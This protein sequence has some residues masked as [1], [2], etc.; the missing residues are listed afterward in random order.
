[1][2]VFIICEHGPA[3][4][5]VVA[6][7][8]VVNTFSVCVD[9][10]RQDGLDIHVHWLVF[11][12]VSSTSIST[13][14]TGRSQTIVST[15]GL[16]EHS[17]CLGHTSVGLS[18]GFVFYIES[19]PVTQNINTFLSILTRLFWLWRLRFIYDY[20]DPDCLVI[21]C[22]NNLSVEIVKCQL[23][24]NFKYKLGMVLSTWHDFKN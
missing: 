16:F 5:W 22:L 15:P 9:E 12:V 20:L 3:A 2:R 11:P 14:W 23:I 13:H 1:M 10:S 7:A 8:T 24:N 17:F 4:V 6:W 18:V 19:Q 21:N